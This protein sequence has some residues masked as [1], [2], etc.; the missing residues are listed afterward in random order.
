[1][2]HRIFLHVGLPKT[3]TTSL[4]VGLRQDSNFGRGGEYA[5]ALLAGDTL[6]A[7][8]RAQT[9]R[10]GQFEP[11]VL[12]F[13]T[14]AEHPALG[15]TLRIKLTNLSA[16]QVNFDQVT[17]RAAAAADAAPGEAAPAAAPAAWA[18]EFAL[19]GPLTRWRMSTISGDA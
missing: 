3:G 16:R 17:L 10:P 4:Q 9:P 14:A 8:R 6:L 2:A 1:M 13:V 11:V 7:E 15:Q 19:N 18:I 12:D 5:L